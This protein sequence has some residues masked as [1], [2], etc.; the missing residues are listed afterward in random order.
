[1]LSQDDPFSPRRAP[2][3]SGVFSFLDPSPI[4][5]CRHSSNSRSAWSSL[6]PHTTEDLASLKQYAN[7]VRAAHGKGNAVELSKERTLEIQSKILKYQA[8]AAA[9]AKICREII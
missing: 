4:L 7:A 2:A 3:R 9:Y 5:F 6:T 8:W 1:V